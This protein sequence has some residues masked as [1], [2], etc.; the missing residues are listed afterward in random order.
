MSVACAPSAGTEEAPTEATDLLRRW[1]AGDPE[2]LDALLPLVYDQLRAAAS[3]YLRGE[4]AACTL[5]TTALVNEVY[6]G[7]AGRD[8]V[9]FEHKAQF[10]GLAGQMIRHI[11][12]S[13]ARRRLA[14]KR[15]A[16]M[17][18]LALE[19]AGAAPA[20]QPLE[21]EALIAVDDAL[22]RLAEF[23]PRQARIVT[24]RFFAGMGFDEIA[25]ALAVSP[26]TVMR[27]WRLA[28]CWLL[29][30]LGADAAS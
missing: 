17:V 25:E 13:H 18:H 1:T 26:S 30:V 11:L 23:S 27:Q 7:L 29:K 14:E 15:G 22:E 12:T 4:S 9:Q 5:H 19:D 3:H 20:A 2:A 28:R 21:A 8:R 10:F 24:L 6:L 16:G